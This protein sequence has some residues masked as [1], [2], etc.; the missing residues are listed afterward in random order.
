MPIFSALYF[1]PLF[2]IFEKYAKNLKIPVSLLS[3]VNDGFF[4]SQEK[5][6]EK[7]NSFL[8]Y[9]YS[10]FSSLLNQFGLV[11]KHGKTEIFHFSDHMDHSILSYLISLILEVLY[12]FLKKSGNI[13]D[14]FLIESFYFNNILT[15]TLTKHCQ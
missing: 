13:W 6:L 2:H 10:I 5:S 7:N 14:L 12:C 15:F 11:I 3:F 8:F 4:I 9:S 1:S